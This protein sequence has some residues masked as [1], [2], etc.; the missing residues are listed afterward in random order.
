MSEPTMA[1]V[2]RRLDGH[3][4]ALDQRVRVDLYERDRSDLKEDI[5]SIREDITG[6]R[7]TLKDDRESRAQWSRVVFATLVASS[8]SFVGVLMIFVLQWIAG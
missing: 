8:L 5:A 2:L 7:T 4:K 3:G 6:I 1:E